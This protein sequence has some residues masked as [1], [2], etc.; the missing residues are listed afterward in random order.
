MNRE[1]LSPLA[2]PV[3]EGLRIVQVARERQVETYLLGGV[4]VAARMPKDTRPLRSREFN[5][6][7]IIVPRSERRPIKQLLEDLGYVG[8]HEFNTINGRSRLLFRDHRNA[9]DLDALVGEF[10]M[11]HELPVLDDATLEHATIPLADLLLTKL[12]IVELNEKDLWDALNLLHA[13]A[14]SAEKADPHSINAGRIAHLCARDWGLWRTVTGNLAVLR[15]TNLEN[16][17][18]GASSAT[19]NARLELIEGVIRNEKK[20]RRWQLRSRIGDR[21]QWFEEP[22]EAH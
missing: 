15:E 17:G 11:C 12:Q 4:A 7:D 19:V 16:E 21:V 8:D 18:V 1:L 2:D 9:R 6:I 14:V 13:H 10:A 22:E 5:D 20:S 3:D